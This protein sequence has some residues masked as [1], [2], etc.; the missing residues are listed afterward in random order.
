MIIKIRRR[1]F[2]Y[3]Y[4]IFTNVCPFVGFSY[5]ILTGFD[6]IREEIPPCAQ[7]RRNIHMKGITLV[8][9]WGLQHS[10]KEQEGR[11]SADSLGSNTFRV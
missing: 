10:K 4:N 5:H 7:V 3:V 6:V 1:R 9:H 2:Y 8:K 11:S